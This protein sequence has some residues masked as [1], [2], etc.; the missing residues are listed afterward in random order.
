MSDTPLISVIIPAF[1]EAEGI[2]DTIARTLR[3][4]EELNGR[5][6]L[7][8]VDD[9]STDQTGTI[10]EALIANEPR[11]KLISF[12]RNFGHQNAISAGLRAAKGDNVAIIDADL[13]DPPELIPEMLEILDQGSDVVYGVRENRKET[14]FKRIAYKVYY[15]LLSWLSERP[16]PRDAGDFCVMRRRVVDELNRMPERGRYIRG[17]RSWVGFRQTAYPYDRLLR[18]YGTSK[19]R[20]R[21]LF[22]LASR[23]VVSS[24]R[25]PLTLAIYIGIALALT[26]FA[27]A[28]KV[29]YVRI[30]YDTAPQGFSA[31]MVAILVIGGVQLIA[32]GVIGMYLSRVLDQVEA[33]PS[34]IVAR[35]IDSS[36]N[37][38]DTDTADS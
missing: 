19:Y 28:A 32:T 15:Y 37:H 3:A 10:V 9:G 21:T 30:V 7:I 34:Y 11:I 2:A 14:F 1:N 6:E 29:V 16:V 36:G 12:S 25:L 17:L 4:L 38:H 20:W 31:L 26:G 5:Q 27:W 8:I 24:S 22:N 13:Q 18:G 23:G 35:H 33:R